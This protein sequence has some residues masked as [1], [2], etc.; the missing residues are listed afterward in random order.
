[1]AKLTTLTHKIAIQLCLV[2]ESCTI[3]SSR[4][5]RPVREILDTTSYL[6]RGCVALGV[7]LTTFIRFHYECYF[8]EELRKTGNRF[9]SS[10]RDKHG[11]TEQ[12]SAC[13]AIIVVLTSLHCNRNTWTVCVCVPVNRSGD[14][15]SSNDTGRR[16]GSTHRQNQCLLSV[17]TKLDYM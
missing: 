8:V 12:V 1:V 4:S 15:C 3:S 13:L 17:S 2:T 6:L 9:N 14:V 7:L 5:R 16:S 10:V 11:Y